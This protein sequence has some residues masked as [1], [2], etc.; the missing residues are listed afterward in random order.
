MNDYEKNQF[1]YYKDKSNRL[2]NEQE[3]SEQISAIFA[4]IVVVLIFVGLVLA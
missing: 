4:L 1:D 2:Q 3:S